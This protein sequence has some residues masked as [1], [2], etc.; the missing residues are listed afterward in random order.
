MNEKQ[1][2]Q[3]SGAIITSFINLHFL[4]EASMSGLFKQ[5]V[6]NN[7]KRTIDDLMSIEYNYFSKIEEV[8]EFQL[9]DKLVAN[10]MEFISMLLSKFKFNDFSKMQ[11][12][13]MAYGLDPDAVTKVSDK[14]LLKNGAK[15]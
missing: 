3:I 4:E 15:V 14:I 11:E 2:E 10:Y 6:K 7:V 13:A 1:L 9:G 8:D 5:R 12:V